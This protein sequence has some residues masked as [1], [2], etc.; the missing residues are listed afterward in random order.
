MLLIYLNYHIPVHISR[1]HAISSIFVKLHHF[2]LALH[3]AC[4]WTVGSHTAVISEELSLTVFSK[5]HEVSGHYY[6]SNPICAISLTCYQIEEDTNSFILITKRSWNQCYW[7][8]S[9]GKIKRVAKQRG[10]RLLVSAQ[11][12]PNHLLHLSINSEVH[13]QLIF[14]R[15]SPKKKHSQIL[16]HTGSKSNLADLSLK[17]QH[18]IVFLHSYSSFIQS[19]FFPVA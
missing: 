3:L 11:H 12:K 17:T 6:S 15:S 18:P 9:L 14:G 8:Y 7:P 1:T 13:V 2:T 16:W 10:I 5:F 4:N 19:F